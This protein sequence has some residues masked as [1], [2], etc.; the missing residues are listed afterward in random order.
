MIHQNSI[1]VEKR[2]RRQRRV[3]AKVIGRIDRPRLNIFRSLRHIT[4]QLIDD[5]AGKTLAAVSDR[6]IKTKGT[7]TEAAQH[8]GEQI[9]AKAKA[10]GITTVVFDRAGYKYHGRVKAIAE[11]ARKG[12][13]VF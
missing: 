1:K 10:L 4:A 9:A 7:K 11:G 6:E 3:R 2:L 5:A 13:L 12:G 8:V